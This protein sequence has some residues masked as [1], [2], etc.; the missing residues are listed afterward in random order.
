M[1][2]ALHWIRSVNGSFSSH[3]GDVYDAGDAEDAGDA[4]DAGEGDSGASGKRDDDMPAPNLR[5]QYLRNRQRKKG[6]RDSTI[7]LFDSRQK[8]RC[9]ECASSAQS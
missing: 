8:S 9:L 7:H 4:G 5:G 6:N 2:M 3:A 1:V